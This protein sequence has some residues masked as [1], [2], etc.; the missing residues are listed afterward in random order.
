MSELIS[1][2]EQILKRKA[3]KV[4]TKDLTRGLFY[5]TLFHLLITVT[6]QFILIYNVP[7][8]TRIRIV[9]SKA[10]IPVFVQNETQKEQKVILG[11]IVNDSLRHSPADYKVPFTGFEIDTS[12]IIHKYE[13]NT[14]NVSILFPINWIFFDNKVKGIIDGIIFLPGENSDYNPQ[15][16][17]LIQ[18]VQDKSL[19]NRAYFDSSFRYNDLDFFIG[20]PQNT[21]GQITQTIYIKTKIYKADFQIKCTSP[22]EAEFKKFQPVFFAMVKSFSAG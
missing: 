3:S 11:D 8:T 9:G 16:S 12:S 20:A 1:K 6:I 15:L 21:F 13:E 19:F 22:N 7:S 10:P 14:L 5:S 18:V 17:V 2:I 4:R